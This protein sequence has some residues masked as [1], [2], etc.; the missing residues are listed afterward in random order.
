MSRSHP[1]KA[2]D[3]VAHQTF[4][5]NLGFS[6]INSS[7]FPGSR[8]LQQFLSASSAVGFE[9]VFSTVAY[10]GRQAATA[11]AVVADMPWRSGSYTSALT[12]RQCSKTASFRATAALFF[13]FFPPRS[14]SLSPYRRRSVSGPNRPKIYCALL[15][16][17]LRTI[18]SPD[19]AFL[20]VFP[21]VPPALPLYP[22]A[23]IV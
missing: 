17:S 20:S 8:L 10:L 19:P 7:L 16:S 14:P 22:A 3:V 15:T 4:P 11:G 5:I 23:S 9:G 12:Q 13:A 2:V 18:V 6:A 21:L 1:N